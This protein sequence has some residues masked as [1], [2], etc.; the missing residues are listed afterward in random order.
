MSDDDA[1][2]LIPFDRS[3]APLLAEW[4]ARPHVAPWHPDPG[5]W[6]RWALNPRQEGAHALIERDGRPIG[7]LRW[8]KVSRDTL[9]S[10]G[11]IEIPEG[12]V[13]IDI[14]IGEAD[15]VGRGLGPRALSVL[16]GTLREDRSIP[17]LTLTTS[18][19][20]AAAQRAF[21]KA[22]FRKLREYEPPGF[23]PFALMVMR[24]DQ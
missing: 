14:L 2:S 4:L 6:L 3:Q 18:V 1:V 7:Y 9:D 13:D 8:R 23:G 20:N 16:A 5:A 10:L 19:L 17:L 21:E 24:L 22:G 12:S 11:L 15:C